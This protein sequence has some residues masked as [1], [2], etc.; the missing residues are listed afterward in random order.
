MR[1]LFT[2][3]DVDASGVITKEDLMELG[4]KG[5]HCRIWGGGACRAH[6][7]PYG[8][9]F[10]HFH[11]HFHRKV[12]MS[13]VQAPQWVHAPLWEILDPPLVSTLFCSSFQFKGTL[14][15]ET[16]YKVKDHTCHILPGCAV[17][18]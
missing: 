10:F 4:K 2:K 16:M 6:A 5:K 7:T 1:F 9:Q 18:L 15:D 12:P 14:L 13:G 17:N 3:Y 8:T 11:I